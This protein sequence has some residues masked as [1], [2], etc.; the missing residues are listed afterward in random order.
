MADGNLI[1]PER[2]AVSLNYEQIKEMAH[3]FARSNMFGVTTP[4]QA[5]SLLM[6]AQSEG[7]HPARALQEYHVIKNK[8]SL[9]AEAMLGRFQH[10][11]GKVRWVRHDDDE[12]TAEFTH[13]ASGTTSVS[14]N[15]DRAK[16]AGVTG[17]DTWKKYPRQMLRAR[18]ISEGVRLSYPACIVGFY[19]PEEV[20][21]YSEPSRVTVQPEPTP[22]PA[23]AVEIEAEVVPDAGQ[24]VPTI[25]FS[26]LDAGDTSNK[27]LRDRHAMLLRGIEG[28]AEITALKAWAKAWHDTIEALPED[29]AADIYAAYERRK[30]ALK[31]RVD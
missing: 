15:M 22:A 5:F 19:T 2:H 4:E 18:V 25:N 3:Y 28:C 1:V 26:P 6:I 7:L 9:K 14:W 27:E 17:N 29:I 8:P 10:A 30:D 13:D 23:A 20:T 21:D 16:K 11:G 12:V 31:A 24:I